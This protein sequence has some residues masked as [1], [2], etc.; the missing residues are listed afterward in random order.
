VR[1]FSAVYVTTFR[2]A[3]R[4]ASA[5]WRISGATGA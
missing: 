4:R 1:R 5:S 3:P 2:C